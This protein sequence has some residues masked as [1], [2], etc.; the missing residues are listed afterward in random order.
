MRPGSKGQ[1]FLSSI[2]LTRGRWAGEAPHPSPHLSDLGD[3]G[4]ATH[5]THRS[6]HR[7]DPFLSLPFIPREV[8]RKSCRK[9]RNSGAE[10]E[11]DQHA[12]RGVSFR[13][14]FLDAYIHGAVGAAGV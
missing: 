13:T 6:P 7:S 5:P 1:G 2:G 10:A 8:P 11:V 14:A 9:N 4:E 12:S 3:A